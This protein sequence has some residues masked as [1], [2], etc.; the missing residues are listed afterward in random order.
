[1]QTKTESLIESSLNIAS[2]FILSLIIWTWLVKPLFNIETSVME[3]LNITLIFTVSAIIRSYVW[4]RYF[5]Y[6]YVR[7]LM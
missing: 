4:R 5:N 7:S 6:R 2:G 3:N 1:M